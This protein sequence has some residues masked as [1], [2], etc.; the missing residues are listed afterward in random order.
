MHETVNRSL[1]SNRKR[2]QGIWWCARSFASRIGF[3]G[4]ASSQLSYRDQP[5]LVFREHPQIRAFAPANLLTPTAKTPKALI[6]PSTIWLLAMGTG[7]F[8]AAALVRVGVIQFFTGSDASSLGWFMDTFHHW[9]IAFLSKGIGFGQG[10]LRL[11]D[12]KGME[13]FWGLLHPL[14]V[15][16]LFAAANSIDILIPRILTVVTGSITAML[17]FVLTKR[18]FGLAAAFGVALFVVLNPVVALADTSGLQEPFGIMFLLFG[19]LL[20]PK[21]PVAAGIVLG[22][23]GMVRAEYWVFG[24]LLAVAAILTEPRK[25]GGWAMVLG[26]MIPT[27]LYMKYMSDYTGNPIYPVY[28]YFLGDAVGQWMSEGAQTNEV[29]VAKWTSWAALPIL[30]AA[31]VWVLIRKPRSALLI[32]LG[33]GELMFLAVVFGFTAFGRGFTTTLLLDRIFLLPHLYV[34]FFAAAFLLWWVPSRTKS[35]IPLLFGALGVMAIAAAMQ[36]LWLP[37]R[38][39]YSS[40]RSAWDQQ[41]KAADAIATFHK[42]GVISIPENV[43]EITYALASRHG[44]PAQLIDGQ[45]YDPFS[46]IEGDPFLNWPET[47]TALKSWLHERDIQLMAFY[48]DKSSYQEMVVRMPDWFEFLGSTESGRIEIFRVNPNA[49][50]PSRYDLFKYETNISP[51]WIGAHPT[52]MEIV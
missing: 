20:W 49:Q 41:L 52:R 46:Q 10:F 6:T 27:L 32:L 45:M 23:A 25:Y 8:L 37:I 4:A 12:F 38:D 17:F 43:P 16:G 51:G 9:Q 40:R 30:A 7:I 36:L 19:L 48:S 28:W 31:A 1:S 15:A 26:W 3:R 14:T 13:Y 5:D 47:E 21:Y 18:Y 2:H 24:G 34:G 44:I 11:W 50:S 39:T 33:I 22:L 29:L 42:G 35:R